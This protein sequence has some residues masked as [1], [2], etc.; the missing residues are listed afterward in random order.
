[1]EGNSTALGIR[2]SVNLPVEAYARCY[3]TVIDEAK[4]SRVLFFAWGGGDL[5][6]LTSSAL[7]EKPE[8][9]SVCRLRDGPY[10]GAGHL[11]I[12]DTGSSRNLGKFDPTWPVTLM[13]WAELDSRQVSFET[14]ARS[15]D[16]FQFPN[17]ASVV[18]F[19]AWL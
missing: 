10:G 16:G 6:A 4:N 8:G 11:V 5:T 12:S 19:H 3:L 9:V 2:F 18:D 15:A 17:Q 14:R 13:F 1:M 7:L